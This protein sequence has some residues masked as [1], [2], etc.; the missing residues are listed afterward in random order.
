MTQELELVTVYRASDAREAHLLRST[1]ARD[2][3]AC[4]I[5]GESLGEVPTDVCQVE[6]WVAGGEALRAR[7]IVEA[8][9]AT[10]TGAPVGKPWRCAH[11]SE[12]NPADFAVCW[13][14]QAEVAAP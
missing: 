14:C 12:E 2:G 11:C 3:I 7:E 1:L 6:L 8:F 10:D 5:R 9:L 4:E 13:K